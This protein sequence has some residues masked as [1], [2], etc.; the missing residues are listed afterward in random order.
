M[1]GFRERLFIPP[2]VKV[3]MKIFSSS[4]MNYQQR[5]RALP[6]CV[7]ARCERTARGLN[8]AYQH[9]AELGSNA[10]FDI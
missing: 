10:L 1:R 3:W 5:N 2:A 6:E 9:V 4:G 7:R 8:A